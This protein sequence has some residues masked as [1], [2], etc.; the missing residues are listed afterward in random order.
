MEHVLYY[1]CI[2]TCI[3]T[4]AAFLFNRLQPGNRVWTISISVTV[5]LLVLVSITALLGWDAAEEKLYRSFGFLVMNIFPLWYVRIEGNNR[6][7][8]VWSL[9]LALVVVMFGTILG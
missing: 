1:L 8:I 5:L 6:R 4:V 9:T 2:A 7:T 3:G